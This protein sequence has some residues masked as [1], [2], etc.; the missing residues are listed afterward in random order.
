MKRQK[1]R[2]ALSLLL[3]LCIAA[4]MGGL[5]F[6]EQYINLGSVSVGIGVN[7]PIS[8]APPLPASISITEKNG[9]PDGCDVILEVNG[10]NALLYLR[11]VPTTEGPYNMVVKL[12]DGEVLKI[13]LTVTP[14]A[15]VDLWVEKTPNRMDYCV[16]EYFDAAGIVLT[17]RYSD[18]SYRNIINDITVHPMILRELGIQNV[19]LSY[20]GKSCILPVNVH[21]PH[22]WV[23]SVEIV[24]L[25]N[26]LTY[27]QGQRLD[28]TGLVLRVDSIMGSYE[29]S[30]GYSCEPNV[31]SG[32]GEQTVLVT[33]MNKSCSYT[34]NMKATSP[35]RVLEI[36][37]EPD[38]TVYTVG[39]SLDTRGLLLV[40]TGQEGSSQL[41]SGYTCTPS[42]FTTAGEQNVIVSYNG[43]TAS[44][45]VTV[46]EKP[47]ATPS[48]PPASPEPSA[49]PESPAVEDKPGNN[50]IKHEK[51]EGNLS[52]GMVVTFVVLAAV[53][54]GGLG[55]FAYVKSQG[56]WEKFLKK[57][58]SKED[59]EE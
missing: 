15:I 48:A 1:L 30:A 3:C 24:R 58:Q 33:Y 52:A 47:A 34:V 53:A 59:K 12:S 6:A 31:L 9:L 21:S 4:S 50:V 38:K 54:L 13:S 41:T 43:L 8:T 27:D 45:T 7:I 42:T 35:T 40:I 19:E 5:A 18:D 10:P 28:T 29:V 26:L 49:P 11:G 25:P 20:E 46:N 16:G 17:A 39:E 14:P 32:S 2:L 22:N 23:N 37:S 36:R 55:L 51:H 44:F 57:L 56:G